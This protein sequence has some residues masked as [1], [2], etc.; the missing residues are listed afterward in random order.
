MKWIVKMM[1]AL[2]LCLPVQS[3]AFPNEPNG[4][5]DLYWGE[6]LQEVCGHYDARF[7]SYMP[8]QNAVMY[9]IQLSQDDS[10]EIE[11][12]LGYA[13][14]NDRISVSFFNDKLF[15]IAVNFKG[16]HSYEL[17]R[18]KLF[19]LYG[20]SSMIGKDTHLWAGKNTILIFNR[21]ANAPDRCDLHIWSA[22]LFAEISAKEGNRKK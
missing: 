3:W 4:F 15:A 17:V 21:A 6:S 9:K 14:E 8:E 22:G 12:I 7:F 5:R 10:R 2:L 13:P 1:L 16:T 20:D 19:R 18:Q 11:D